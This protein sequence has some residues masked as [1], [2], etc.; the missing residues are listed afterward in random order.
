MK[1]V[2]SF[3]IGGLFLFSQ[4]SCVLLPRDEWGL[5]IHLVPL[6]SPEAEQEIWAA[7]RS[8]ASP[9]APFSARAA[10]RYQS[11]YENLD[12]TQLIYVGE[13]QKLAIE[14]IS[15]GK[16][17]LKLSLIDN[18]VI[19][20][21]PLRKRLYRSTAESDSL[22]AFPMLD[23]G[24]IRLL[25]LISGKIMLENFDSYDVTAGEKDGRAY[26]MLTLLQ[27]GSPVQQVLVDTKN[28]QLC[29]VRYARP[30][31]TWRYRVLIAGYRNDGLPTGISIEDEEQGRLASLQYEVV[32]LGSPNPSL[33]EIMIPAG[34]IEARLKP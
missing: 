3:F 17:L 2:L 6:K 32:A 34:T 10:F 24:A 22:S 23:L 5:G 31:G 25:R 18:N 4:L 33:F 28:Q 9:P 1:P 15:F 21:E 7:V 27:K 13:E 29:A 26:A 20:Y 16:L 19:V 12:L 8:L 30:A 11:H 14:S